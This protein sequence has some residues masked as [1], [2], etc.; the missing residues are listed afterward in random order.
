MAASRQSNLM[1]S[2]FFSLVSVPLQCVT[3]SAGKSS[4]CRLSSALFPL[5]GDLVYRPSSFGDFVSES[6]S[7]G[8]ARSASFGVAC[9]VVA[10][11]VLY[12]LLYLSVLLFVAMVF[13]CLGKGAFF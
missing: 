7:D 1:A 3:T 8:M 5:S 2:E 13:K 10:A 11:V 6:A 9:I 12:V 4:F